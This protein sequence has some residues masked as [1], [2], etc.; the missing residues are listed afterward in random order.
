M[1]HKVMNEEKTPQFRMQRTVYAV[2]GGNIYYQALLKYTV[3][4]PVT[5]D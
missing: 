4:G 5:N 3:K 1:H 2:P